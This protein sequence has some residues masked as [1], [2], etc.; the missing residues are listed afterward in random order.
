MA[1]ETKEK[2]SLFDGKAI[3]NYGFKVVQELI[4]VG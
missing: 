4:G 2:K 1:Q 3:L